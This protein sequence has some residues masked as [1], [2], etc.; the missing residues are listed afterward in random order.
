MYSMEEGGHDFFFC[1]DY[2]WFQFLCTDDEIFTSMTFSPNKIL[3][4]VL[5]SPTF[6][7]LT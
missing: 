5:K 2:D 3:P 4:A 1:S 6:A 7:Y